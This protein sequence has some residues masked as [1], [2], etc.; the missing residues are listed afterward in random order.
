M[1]MVSVISHDLRRG[2]IVDVDDPFSGVWHILAGSEPHG[3][4]SSEKVE[5]AL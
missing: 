2:K 5:P 4:L 3:G 1:L